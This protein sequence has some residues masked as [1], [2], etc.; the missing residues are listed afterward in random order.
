VVRATISLLLLTVWASLSLATAA[1]AA[2]DPLSLDPYEG[3]EE[4]EVL[5]AGGSLRVDNL[6]VTEGIQDDGM[7]HASL[8]FIRYVWNSTIFADF[9]NLTSSDLR[10]FYIDSNARSSFFGGM[11]NESWW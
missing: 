2:E 7:T 6:S 3:A 9:V 11:F 1:W 8:P 4:L 5:L 10:P